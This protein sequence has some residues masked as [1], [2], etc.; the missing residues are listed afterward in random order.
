MLEFG[1]PF[2]VI[3]E[4]AEI[5]NLIVPTM[6]HNVLTETM[7]IDDAVVEAERQVNEVLARR[8]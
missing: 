5:M 6:I 2:P 7:S 8:E 1:V 4:A 3:P